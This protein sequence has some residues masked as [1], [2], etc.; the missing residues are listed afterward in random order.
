MV[1]RLHTDPENRGT[2]AYQLLTPY[3]HGVPHVDCEG[4]S[5]VTRTN[6]LL[7]PGRKAPETRPHRESICKSAGVSRNHAQHVCV[8]TGRRGNWCCCYPHLHC[9]WR[10]SLCS[11]TTSPF[12]LP[13]W[14]HGALA[15]LGGGLQVDTFAAE[16]YSL[17]LLCCLVLWLEVF[18]KDSLASGRLWTFP[19]RV[20]LLC[21]ARRS[22][23]PVPYCLSKG[24]VVGR[25]CRAVSFG[26]MNIHVLGY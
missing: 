9:C 21:R 18:C 6:L 17:P 10:A 2:G 1:I 8:S 3:T 22:P 16:W 5:A 14:R 12:S 24:V 11:R 13:A 26:C 25:S 20:G 15:P 7:P 23:Q 19:L 4:P